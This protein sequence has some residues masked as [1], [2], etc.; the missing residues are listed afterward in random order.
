M[1]RHGRPPQRDRCGQHDG[2]FQQE[3][4]VQDKV[5]DPPAVAGGNLDQVHLEISEWLQ[6]EDFRRNAV[7]HH[8]QQQ[9]GQGDPDEGVKAGPVHQARHGPGTGGAGNPEQ[10]PVKD[11]SVVDRLPVIDKVEPEK[12]RVGQ[13]RGDDAGQD[14]RLAV[15]VTPAQVPRQQ[16]P[17]GNVGHKHAVSGGGFG[18]GVLQTGGMP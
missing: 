18:S 4:P 11:V 12:V 10:G 17:G 14:Q 16:I 6:P 13:D 5:P 2:E 3:G 8:M 1:S 9:A 7:Q 15:G